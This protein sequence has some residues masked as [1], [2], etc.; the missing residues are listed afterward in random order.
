[1]SP[2][3]GTAVPKHPTRSFSPDDGGTYPDLGLSSVSFCPFT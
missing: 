2:R 3:L 1:L